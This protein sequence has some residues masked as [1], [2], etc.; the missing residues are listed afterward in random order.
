M[1]SPYKLAVVT[2]R[3]SQGTVVQR[4]ITRFKTE[5]HYH[6]FKKVLSDYT[7]LEFHSI[8]IREASPPEGK[9][10]KGTLWCPYCS[11]WRKFSND[12]GY[13][14]CEICNISNQDF[15][16]KNYNVKLGLMRKDD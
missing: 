11:K 9:G 5:E 14:R 8:N 13:S 2:V 7:N 15:Y 10:P 16:T 4:V 12:N 6:K 1:R 3:R